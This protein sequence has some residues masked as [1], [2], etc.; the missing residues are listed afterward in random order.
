MK[1]IL[2]VLTLF[3][4]L[5]YAWSVVGIFK[6]VESQD[7]GQYR[8]L[9]INSIL[10]WASILHAV[11]IADLNSFLFLVNILIQIGCG[12][13]FWVH[14][15]IAKA[16]RFSVVYSKDMPIS[17]IRKGFY[18]KIRHPF[19][20]IYLLTYFSISLSTMDPYSLF[21][22]LTILIIYF[23]AAKFEEAKF[24]LSPMREDYASYKESTGMFLPKMR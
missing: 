20:M 14:S 9:Q 10:L 13:S 17:L 11:W 12:V 15:R 21:F 16:S 24:S 22:S 7:I 23:R 1:D 5:S 19:Y 6:T 18:K 8:L 3:N 2:F 4:I